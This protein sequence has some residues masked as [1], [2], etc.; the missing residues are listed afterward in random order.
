MQAAPTNHDFGH[1]YQRHT[2]FHH[3]IGVA[4][5]ENRIDPKEGIKNFKR[6]QDESIENHTSDFG[7]LSQLNRCLSGWSYP[8]LNCPIYLSWTIGTDCLSSLHDRKRPKT[9]SNSCCRGDASFLCSPIPSTVSYRCLHHPLG[10]KHT[11]QT[12]VPSIPNISHKIQ[13]RITGRD[14]RGRSSNAQFRRRKPR[15][16]VKSDHS[17]MPRSHH[18]SLADHPR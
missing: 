9:T 7:R 8:P 18:P 15:S 1:L 14:V 4:S 10:T 12:L 17:I 16:I 6:V 2:T 3:V 13:R 11:S 5:S